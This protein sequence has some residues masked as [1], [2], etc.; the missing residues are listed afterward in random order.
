MDTGRGRR[1]AVCG[2]RGTSPPPATVP[3][4]D[5]DGVVARLCDIVSPPP[6]NEAG[7]GIS[8]KYEHITLLN[9]KTFRAVSTVG[10]L[11]YNTLLLYYISYL[12]QIYYIR[13]LCVKKINNITPRNPQ[14]TGYFGIILKSVYI[15]F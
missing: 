3:S 8:I 9:R 6:D 7:Y 13:A 12:Q 1:G 2:R 11:N 5:T 15:I 10:N 4:R 14:Y